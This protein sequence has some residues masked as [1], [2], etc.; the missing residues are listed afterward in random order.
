MPFGCQ[1]IK[2]GTHDARN[3]ASCL[4][5]TDARPTSYI[6][7]SKIMPVNQQP[8]CE[9]ASIRKEVETFQLFWY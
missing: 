4:A 1:C 6:C 9:Q 5:D 2:P 8:A 7:T 3:P